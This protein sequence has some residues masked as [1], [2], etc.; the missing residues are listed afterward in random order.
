MGVRRGNS[1]ADIKRYAER[2]IDVFLRAYGRNA[3]AK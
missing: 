3:D 1:R 2:A